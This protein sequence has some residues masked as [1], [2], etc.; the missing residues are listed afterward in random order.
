MGW[1]WYLPNDMQFFLIL[2]FLVWLLY[3]Y[4]TVGV[5]VVWFLTI[6]SFGVTFGIL[7]NEEYSPSYL[8]I[9]EDYYRVYYMKP[10]MRIAP[11]L[12]GVY[13][14]FILFCFRNDQPETSFRKRFCDSIKNSWILRQVC[15]WVGLAIMISITFT[16]YNVNRKPDDYSRLFNAIYMSL[17]RAGFIV[18][19][20]LFILPILLGRGQA[21]RAIMG[22]EFMTP[23]AR[24]S[25]GMYLIHP[26]YMLFES[27]NRQR[28]TWVTHNSNILAAFGWWSVTVITS[29]LFTI[30]IETPCANL[31]KT[32]LMGGKGRNSKPKEKTVKVAVE[33]FENSFSKGLVSKNINEFDEETEDSIDGVWDKKKGDKDDTKGKTVKYKIN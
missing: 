13:L 2:P 32:F 15:Y 33:S 9:R 10:Y 6:A 24:V 4:R 28:A 21:L 16:F 12:L 29:F 18:G 23:L 11:F 22:H 31:E 5:V 19:L 20:V 1:T 8:R 14:G 25:F 7:Y 17:I 26:T 30:V 3:H 27:F